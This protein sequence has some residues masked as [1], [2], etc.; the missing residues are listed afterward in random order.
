MVLFP[1][2]VKYYVLKL[3]TQP[4]TDDGGGK[5]DD[6]QLKV[7]LVLKKLGNAL[8]I[9][10]FFVLRS[11]ITKATVSMHQR[12]NVFDKGA[13]RFCLKQKSILA[14]IAHLKHLIVRIDWVLDRNDG[15]HKQFKAE[16][17]VTH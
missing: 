14:C 17:Y 2:K 1:P 3:I 15:L 8:K 16:I 10:L 12:L 11:S 7:K 13:T 6:F 5:F 4:N 9:F